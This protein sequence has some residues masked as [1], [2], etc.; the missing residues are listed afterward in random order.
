MA[1]TT[2]QAT[3]HRLASESPAAD[4]HTGHPDG[5]RAGRPAPT[6][7]SPTAAA[8][9]P[10]PQP[11][12]ATGGGPAPVR[13]PT[14]TARPKQ[15]AAATAVPVQDAATT[16]AAGARAEGAPGAAT[17]TGRGQAGGGGRVHCRAGERGRSGGAG[18][19][20]AG[21]PAAPLVGRER[22]D[23]DGAGQHAEQQVA[24][25]GTVPGARRGART[26]RSW[27]A[28]VIIITLTQYHWIQ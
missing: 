11:H 22:Q 14:N 16:T 28:K 8:P 2:G 15:S 10:R 17:G 9:N 27:N 19:V 26:L 4:N 25:W 12:T 24:E 13:R 20:A 3:G 6:T 1:A 7:A 18:A 5:T 23:E 21:R